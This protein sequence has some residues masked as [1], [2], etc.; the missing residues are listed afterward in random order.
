MVEPLNESACKVNFIGK[1]AN[2]HP[3]WYN[4]P[5]RLNEQ[6]KSD[7]VSVLQEFF[8]SYHL[9][10]IREILWAWTV[11][12]VSSPNSFSNDHHERNNHFFF[13]EKV[14]QLIEA[15]WRIYSQ[16]RTAGSIFKP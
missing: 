6:E 12:V 10:D 3:E 13:Y 4:T 2:L 8:Q 1:K 11:T 16:E 14:E 9:N 5:L 7:P 15:C